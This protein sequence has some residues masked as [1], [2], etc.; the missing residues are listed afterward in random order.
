MNAGRKE[1]IIV[2]NVCQ[3]SNSLLHYLA[4]RYRCRLNATPETPPARDCHALMDRQMYTPEETD[5][6]E[7]ERGPQA[8]S[9]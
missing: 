3:W 4:N 2:A 9:S 8:S 5:R 7:S 1:G 6:L